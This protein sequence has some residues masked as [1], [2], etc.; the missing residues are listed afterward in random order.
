LATG[1]IG[2]LPYIGGKRRI[3]RQLSALIPSHIAYVEAFA[4]GA[5]VFFHK[6]R[7]KVEVLNDLDGEVTNFFRVVQR[8]PEELSRWL[9]FQPASRKIFDDHKRQEPH[10]LTDIE[11]AARFYY[12][13][14]NAWSGL[15]A[16]P[17]F[18]YAVTKPNNHNPLTLPKRLLDTADRLSRVQIENLPYGEVIARYD[19]PTT[20]FYFDPPYVGVDLYHHNFTDRQ[21]RELAARLDNI[22]GRFLLSINDCAKARVWF[23]AF[24]RLEISFTYTS[25]KGA[26][27][28]REL[29]FANYPLPPTLPP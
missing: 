1:L 28:Y 10:V 2:P 27:Q 8:H 26:G 19:R 3:A 11:R 29:L 14:K 23:R 12:L 20:F 15:R 16:R 13:Q 24:H 7:S 21:F 4:G 9:R 17:H 5:Q 22:R 18:H 6:P 25:V